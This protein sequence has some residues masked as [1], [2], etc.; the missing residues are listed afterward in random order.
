MIDEIIRQFKGFYLQTAESNQKAV[1]LW[2]NYILFSWRWWFALG[3]LIIPW[4]VWFY[5]RPKKNW[6]SILIAGLLSY[7]IASILDSVG[8]AYGMWA[9]PTIIFP[10][11][12]SFYVPWDLTA[13]PV[14]IMFFLQYKKNISVYIKAIVYALISALIAE[15]ILVWMKVYVPI[16]WKHYYGIPLYFMIY[17][18][19]DKVSQLTKAQD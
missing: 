19:V 18:I 17:L 13:V 4:I 3:L 8:V 9:Y 2:K 7:V 15:P 1:E 6:Q 5:L 12:H 10:Y 16:T 14:L 11:L